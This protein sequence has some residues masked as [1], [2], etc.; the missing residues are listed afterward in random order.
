[1]KLGTGKKSAL[2]LTLRGSAGSFSVKHES[3]ANPT[4]DV[5][6]FLTHIGLSPKDDNSQKTLDHLAPFREIF[7]TT[8]LHF[9]E[10]LQRDIDD[11]RVSS[12]LI[13]YILD[14]STSSLVKFFPPIV[15]VAMPVSDEQNIPIDYYPEVFTGR[16]FEDIHDNDHKE[17]DSIRSGEI[18]S[19]VFQL[20]R[21]VSEGA[22]LNHDFVHFSINKNKCKL[23]IVDG[24][25]RAMALLALYRNLKSKWKDEG[26]PFKSFYEEW[27]ADYIKQ[28]DLENIQMPAI[29][30]TI[31][32]LDEKF[33]LKGDYTLKKASRSIFLT[34]NKTAQPVSKSRNQLLDDSDIVSSFLRRALDKIKNTHN[35]LSSEGSL[36]IYN[37]ELDQN[38]QQKVKNSIA[39]SSVSHLH[40]IVE[41][42]LLAGSNDIDGISDRGGA[43]SRRKR[44]YF[45]N[46]LARLNASEFLTDSEMVGVN[47]G[48][49]STIAEKKFTDTFEEKY[50]G[51]ILSVFYKFTPFKV[52]TDATFEL[53]ERMDEKSDIEISSMFFGGQSGIKVFE[54]HRANLS[55]KLT[56]P[57]SA[58]KLKM[59]VDRLNVKKAALTNWET[60]LFKYRAIRFLSNSAK[61]DLYNDELGGDLHKGIIS[62]INQLYDNV[63][64]TVAFQAATMC[65]F[66]NIIE[67]HLDLDYQESAVVSSFDSYLMSINKFFTVES[68]DDFKKLIE[69]FIGSTQGDTASN[70]TKPIAGSELT[71]K[72]IL[73]PSEMKPDSWPRY[74]YLL[75]ELWVP[76]NDDNLKEYIESE[77]V[78]CR[79]EVFHGL[80]SRNKKEFSKSTTI[81]LDKLSVDDVK[82]IHQ[83][84]FDQYANFLGEYFRK[85]SKIS[86]HDFGISG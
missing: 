71:F 85:K 49:F 76:S 43:F 50:I 25:H 46:A 47:R 26:K 51:K 63:F 69:L 8:D 52:H 27:D 73:S 28:F 48:E 56:E 40:Y 29:I 13:P 24:Q 30:C 2:D 42:L 58:P 83:T 86:I 78:K 6:Y 70:L 41:H 60:E 45:E 80:F 36:K 32:E 34:L 66:F 5:K 64:G 3:N 20:D 72:N 14:K 67:G 75:L 10:I 12:K 22:V 39:I 23:V 38:S 82:K 74:R 61:K 81:P 11:A 77:L 18:G 21:P 15:I 55:A 19:E 37:I 4:L 44:K 79:S 17:W 16:V 65:T 57:K 31:P 68:F 59:I 53:S 7:D 84:T 62:L 35:N 33:K 1:M 9:D 54:D